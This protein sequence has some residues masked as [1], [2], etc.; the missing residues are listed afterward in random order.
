MGSGD[1]VGGRESSLS[2]AVSVGAVV[3]VGGTL[4]LFHAV[5]IVTASGNVWTV[6][7]G[8]VTSLSF[9]LA[10]VAIG[11]WVGR[12]WDAPT[13]GRLAVWCV[14]GTAAF[15]V[16]AVLASVL[17]ESQG[18]RLPFGPR[19][20]GGASSVGALLGSVLGIY[21]ARQ[22]RARRR[23]HEVKARTERLNTRL[24]R[25]N[26][27][28]MVL[29]RV[30]RHNVRNDL[31]VVVGRAELVADRNDGVDERDARTIVDVAERLV[32]QSDKARTLETLMET[33]GE[34]QPIDLTAVVE[35]E[36][37]DLGREYPAIA[38]EAEMPDEQP[39]EAAPSLDTAVANVLDNAA[40]H[41][42]A[43]EPRL[44]VT[45]ARE[46]DTVTLTV[47]DNGPGIPD[48][49]LDVLDAGAETK[50]K[51]SSGLGL[52]TAVWVVEHSDGDIEFADNDPHGTVVTLRFPAA[53]NAAS[54]EFLDTAGVEGLSAV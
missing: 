36:L 12:R 23:W 43:E 48:H 20:F 27:R 29:N 40:R 42:D 5:S 41:N 46:D 8:G 1:R 51:H 2:R 4:A 44:S 21:D 53:E 10:V 22:V 9:S 54:L 14:G 19:W 35:R 24:R 31:N 34:A 18:G 39:V 26:E 3:L 15:G 52:W 28:L 25:S 33:R 37:A 38:V 45:V 6:L 16:L 50:L 13:T 11:V 7:S 47:V 30:L 17:V 49:E 32:D